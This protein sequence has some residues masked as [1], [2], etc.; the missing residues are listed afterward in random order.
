MLADAGLPVID[1]A[2]IERLFGL[3]RRQAIELMHGFGGYQ[4]GRTFL[5]GRDQLIAQLD[6]MA[7]GSEY[8]LE[9]A[10]RE[11]LTATLERL[12]RTRQAQAVKIVAPP[13]AFGSR[14][15]TLAPGVQLNPGKLEIEFVD[16]ADLLSKLFGLSQAIANDYAGFERASTSLRC[17]A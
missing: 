13:E 4:A 2:V 10:R 17:S 14:M 5:I 15:N 1:R 12:Q 3:G 6:A 11:K 7:T 8:R 16:P 9:V